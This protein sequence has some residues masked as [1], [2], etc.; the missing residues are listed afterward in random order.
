MAKQ[1]Q[2]MRS[3][4]SLLNVTNLKFKTQQGIALLESMIAIVIFSMGILALA[5]LQGVLVKNTSDAKYRAEATFIAQQR[6]GLI[7][8]GTGLADYIE[9]DTDISNL[10]PN[11]TRTVAISPERVVTVTVSWQLPG[12]EEHTYSTNAR[13]EGI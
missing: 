11:G 5:G 7:W 1:N 6:L 3:R 4:R 9:V 13:I 2:L 8:V 12:E 10:L